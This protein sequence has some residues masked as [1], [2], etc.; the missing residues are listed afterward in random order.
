MTLA[1]TGAEAFVRMLQLH[2]VKHVF[3]LCGDTSLP[4]GGVRR[5][6]RRTIRRSFATRSRPRSVR[7][8]WLDVVCQPLQEAHAPV[9][10]W[11]A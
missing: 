3:G 8:R 11:I 4:R 10:E 5:A 6:E 9:S 2:G 7:R 1:V